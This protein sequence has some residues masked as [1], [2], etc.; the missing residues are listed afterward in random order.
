[1][2]QD[3]TTISCPSCQTEIDVNDI[4]YHQVNEQLKQKYQQELT[5]QQQKFDAQNAELKKQ[6][7]VLHEAKAQQ[8]QLVEQLVQQQVNALVKQKESAL[9]Q[10]I[11]KQAAEEQQEALALLQ[12]ELAD[13][14]NKVKAVSY[15]HLTLP[16][17]PYV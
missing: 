9:V 16:T 15:T 11:S 8:D 12:A 17:T 13:K 2:K 10:K 7:A 6:Q 3:Q 5:Q 1:M 14:S 4:L